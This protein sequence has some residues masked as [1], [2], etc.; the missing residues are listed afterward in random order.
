MCPSSR[1]GN[2]PGSSGRR[3]WTDGCARGRCGGRRCGTRGT[4]VGDQDG[5]GAAA[6]PMAEVMA[7]MPGV[8]RRLLAAHV[9]DRFGRCSACRSATG[10]GEKW[11]CSL[12]RIATQ[13]RRLH[14]QNLAQAID[15]TS[16]PDPSVGRVITPSLARAAGLLLGAAADAVLGDPRRG[17][18]V[19]G[20][21]AV[22]AALERRG[23]AD[24]RGA[25]VR[26]VAVLVGGA[27]ALGAAAERAAGGLGRAHGGDGAGDVGGA[28]RDVAG[29]G[30]C[31]AG[32]RAGPRRPRGGAGTVARVCAG[33]TRRRST[34]AASPG[35]APSR[36]R[37]T[38][39]TPWSPRCSGARW[40]V[41]PG[42]SATGR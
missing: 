4:T 2:E 12:H 10:S 18:P 38:P 11:P 23:Y 33:A 27:V 24:R 3:Q 19:A 40:P 28:G 17:H 35:R 15:T 1:S 26:H 13:A 6:V 29:T 8:W 21:G 31:G 20:F 41:C 9:P 42:C 25:G 22:A 7:E 39:R 14:E 30:G 36:W 37:R 32:R 34:R 16:R 5:D